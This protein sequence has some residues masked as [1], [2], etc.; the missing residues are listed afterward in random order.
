MCILNTEGKRVRVLYAARNTLDTYTLDVV[1][2]FTTEIFL[3]NSSFQSGRCLLTENIR[4][5]WTF[6]KCS[7][8]YFYVTFTIDLL[9]QSISNI[10]YF[11]LRKTDSL[12]RRDIIKQ[13]G[14]EKTHVIKFD[15]III[16]TIL[17]VIFVEF[18]D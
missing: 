18:T 5:P 13:Y 17:R 15:N 3:L 4:L 11:T 16:R 2:L 8:R 7:F 9:Y 6:V 12:N 14:N 10:L 1:F